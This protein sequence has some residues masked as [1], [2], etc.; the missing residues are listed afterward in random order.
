MEREEKRLQ[1][2]RRLREE[3][4]G[5]PAYLVV[6]IDISKDIHN[7]LMRTSGGK[8]L[9]RRL[10]FNNTREGFE[11]LLLQVEAVRVQ[12]SLK[13]VVFGMEPT[14]NYHKPLGEF[15]IS[16][17]QQVVL[18]SPEAAKQN[19][20]LLDGRWKKHDRKE[21][22]KNADTTFKGKGVFL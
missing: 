7:A 19:R 11:T 18:V 3:I 9:Y 14:A 12:Q 4:C 1:E 6:G 13:E 5:S 15:L 16:R 2:V 20:P 22:G 8:I 17:D 10:T 21:W